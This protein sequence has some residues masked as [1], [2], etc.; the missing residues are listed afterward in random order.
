MT[1]LLPSSLE[2]ALTSL[3][4][5]DY[6][7]LAGGTDLYPAAN[8][9]PVKGPVID[10]S[11]LKDFRGVYRE[12][13][14]YRIGGLTTWTDIA[15]GDLPA[16]FEALQMAAREVGSIQ[17]QNVG[18]IAGNLCNASPAADGVPALLALNAEVEL[19]SLNGIR[20][21]PLDRFI[22]GNRRTAIA[23]NELLSA[24]IIPDD[25]GRCASHFLKLGARRYL[26]ISIVMVA[27]VIELGGNGLISDAR[28]AVGACSE[29]AQ[30]LPDL[31][32]VLVGRDPRTATELVQADHFE[33]LSPITDV[34][35]SAEYRE[36]AAIEM[37]RRVV[38]VCGEKLS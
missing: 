18:T 33:G 17:I 16:Q 13:G 4:E 1:Y 35:A 38:S 3:S 32:R 22:L 28:I 25:V 24:V 8:G 11:G 37:V 36:A 10:L 34:R 21:L 26:V 30:R 9:R 5:G 6:T 19:T 7:I 27:A 20:R 2:E 15:L 12:E 23:S 14:G 29:V 31:E